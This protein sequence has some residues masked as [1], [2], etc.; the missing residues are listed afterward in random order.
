MFRGNGRG[1]VTVSGMLIDST[2]RWQ[3]LEFS[4]ATDQT[5]LGHFLA[6]LRRVTDAAAT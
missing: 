2:E 3:K 6:E 5:A 4:F 1:Q